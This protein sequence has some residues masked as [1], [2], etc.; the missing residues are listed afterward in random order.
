M[1]IMD[2]MTFYVLM[3]ILKMSRDNLFP[4]YFCM[5]LYYK[6]AASGTEISFSTYTILL[7][8]LLA[9][10]NWRKY[11]EVGHLIPLRMH[12]LIKHMHHLAL[13]PRL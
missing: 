8:N 7:K 11:I 1:L 3:F 4:P 9:V 10:G 2:V 13:V 6:I 12:L 5:Q